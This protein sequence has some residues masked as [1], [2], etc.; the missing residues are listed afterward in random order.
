MKYRNRSNMKVRDTSVFR[1]S[2]ADF[3]NVVKGGLFYIKG[4]IKNVNSQGLT[5]FNSVLSHISRNGKH[6]NETHK[7][8]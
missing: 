7:I 3:T 4:L 6:T 1:V 2:S 8:N 5:Y